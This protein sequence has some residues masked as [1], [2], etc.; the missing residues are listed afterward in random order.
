MKVRACAL[1]LVA[2]AGAACG[3]NPTAN[4]DGGGGGDG[5][6]E[7]TGPDGA[8][9][10]ALKTVFVLLMENH[11]WSDIAGSASAPYIN[12]TLLPMSSYCENYFD[13]PKDVHPSEPNYIWIESGDNLGITDDNDPTVNHQATTDHLVTYLQKANVTWRSYQESISGTTCPITS[14]GLYG[15]KHNPMV[16]FD[17]V[18]GNPPDSTNANCIAH[19]RPYSELATDLAADKVARY[20]FITPNLCDDMHNSTGCATTDEVKNGDTWL[21]TEVPKIL[22]SNAYKNGG[23]LFI[24][25]D[26]SEGGEFP[27]GMIVLSPKAKGGGYKNNI[28][29]YHSS[30]LRTVEEVFGVTP[31][32]RDAANQPDLADLFTSFP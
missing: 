11:N 1:G 17:D 9:P 3:G 13:N 16:F 32:L 25:W 21:S 26:E 5:G 8:G 24:T 19:V 10:A 6:S 28:K 15:A 31:L 18:V 22:A 4:P 12:K 30:L 7:A 2:L 14:S 27:I 23:A 20:N 29:Y